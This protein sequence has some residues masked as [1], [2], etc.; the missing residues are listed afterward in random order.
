MKIFLVSFRRI[1]HFGFEIKTS[2]RGRIFYTLLE[3]FLI[4]PIL[5]SALEDHQAFIEHIVK[6]GADFADAIRKTIKIS[7]T[8]RR[9][10]GTD[11]TCCGSKRALR[12]RRAVTGAAFWAIKTFE[13]WVFGPL[14]KGCS[15][16]TSKSRRA[17]NIKLRAWRS[18]E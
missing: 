3:S 7:H 10:R 12:L 13:A 5:L 2:S 18:S 15:F 14:S 6:E 1:G 4:V 17:Q 16:R 8:L 11:I 9:L